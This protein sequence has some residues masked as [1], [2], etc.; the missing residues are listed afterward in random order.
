MAFWF[1]LLIIVAY[2]L[3]SLPLS[4]W[5][6]R[7]L[8]GIDLRQY[9]TGQ[10][11]AG[12]LYRM[13]RSLKFGLAVGLFDLTKGMLMVW[14]ARLVGLDMAQQ[15]VVGMTAIVGHNWSVFLRFSG[16]RG[17][18]T[19]IGVILITPIINGLVPWGIIAF[20]LIVA[21]GLP[22]LR[23]SPLPILFGV[24]ATP[25]ASWLGHEPLA[26]TLGYLATLLILIMKRLTVPFSADANS[27][28]R[29]E[30]LLNRLLFDRDIKDRRGWMYR[31]PLEERKAD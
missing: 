24:A 27:I 12:N 28:S 29:K 31:K 1:V 16:G 13:T 30:L 3:G 17:V 5:T 15:L 9:G 23:S 26:V 18:G 14:V 19:T 7:L 8:K 21:I 2:L 10:V 6:A 4:Y 20:L 22:V 11:G 25:V